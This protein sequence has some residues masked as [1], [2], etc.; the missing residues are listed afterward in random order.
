M[1]WA[2]TTPK[3]LAKRAVRPAYRLAVSSLMAARTRLDEIRWRRSA[4]GRTAMHRLHMLHNAYDGKRCF[5]IGNGPSLRN[6]D[7]GLLKNEVTIGCNGLFLLFDEM[8]FLPTFYTVEDQLVAEDRAGEIEKITGT[9]KIFPR[10]LSYCLP[11]DPETIFVNFPRNYANF[12]RFSGRFDRVAY[13][14]GTVTFFNLQLAYHIGCREVYVVGLD[15]SYKVPSYATQN[16]IVSREPDVNHFHPDYFGTGYRWHD[17]NVERMEQSYREAARYF[18][19][20]GGVVYNAT[21]GG[22]LE[23]FPRR[24]FESLF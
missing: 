22:Q 1:S 21:V 17:P 19:A 9:T 3:R 2:V 5:I 7:L 24:H 11:E 6:T 13:F 16:V 10:D 4:E 12:P 23:V 15:H 20:H 18:E 8:G 14:G